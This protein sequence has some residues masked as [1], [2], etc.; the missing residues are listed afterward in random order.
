MPLRVNAH[1]SL[2]RGLH[3]VWLLNNHRPFFS[4]SPIADPTSA[5]AIRPLRNGLALSGASAY[6]GRASGGTFAVPTTAGAVVAHVTA[7]HS[8]TDGLAHTICHFGSLYPGSAGTPEFYLGKWS[9]NT[10]LFG[11]ANGG[12]T[13]VS[14]SASGTYASGDTFTVGGSWTNGG[15]TSAY[16]KGTLLT[17]SGTAGATGSTA[18]HQSIGAINDATAN[19]WC[20]GNTDGIHYVAFWDRQLSASEFRLLEFDPYCFFEPDFVLLGKAASSTTDGAGAADGTGAAT[21]TGAAIFSGVGAAD[22]TG[23]AAGVGASTAAS[24]GAAEGTGAAAGVGASTAASEGASAGLGDAAGV[25]A[26]TA[27]GVGAADGLG[28]AAGIADSPAVGAADGTGAAA[29]VGTGI[30][31]GSG[32][33]DGLSD[34]LGVGVAIFSGSGASAGTGEPLAVGASTFAGIGLA[35]GVGTA[36]GITPTNWN[37]RR[38]VT[39]MTDQRSLISLPDTRMLEIPINRQNEA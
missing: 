10:W 7:G 17:S 5:T 15:A 1:H 9:D 4:K 25:G 22:G 27:E 8:P 20:R 2:A 32:A 19:H 6:V 30:G 3:A 38:L 13:W 23:A 28:A 39:V 33:A 18:G 29:G 16:C 14:P 26:S 12:T 21:G 34:A 37:T 11:W 31:S 36:L 24:D 35:A